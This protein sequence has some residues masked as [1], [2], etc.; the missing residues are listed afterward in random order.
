MPPLP[1]GS[2]RRDRDCSKL[3]ERCGIGP[4]GERLHLAKELLNRT[5]LSP[6]R[7]ALREWV[8]S[9]WGK[10]SP[11]VHHR[12]VQGAPPI[13]PRAQRPP[14]RMPTGS[15]K[16]LLHERDG[17]RCR[18]CG[19]PVI[20]K[21]VRDRFRELYPEVMPW[22]KTNREQH[23]AFQVMWAQ[24]DHI[25]PHARGGTNDLDNIVVACA[26]C[27]FGRMNYLVEEVGLADPRTRSPIQS[28]WDG[29]ERLLL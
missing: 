9:L 17:Y 13:L 27:N 18:F 6:L 12:I 4:F 11:Y 21:E 2:N 24:Y 16:R 1:S 14:F 22:G 19:I 8:E 23:A 15:E 20:R 29:L 25:V 3:P 7:K 26:P 28:T 10:A 5:N